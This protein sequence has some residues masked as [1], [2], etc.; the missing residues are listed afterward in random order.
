MKQCSTCKITKELNCFNYDK[1]R[2]SFKAKC[3]QCTAIVKK[4]WQQNNKQSMSKSFKKWSSKNKEHLQEYRIL[5]KECLIYRDKIRRR[6]SNYV[7]H[8]RLTDPL[9]LFKDKLRSL[10][11]KSLKNK[12][13]K[14]KSKTRDIVGLDFDKLKNYL[15]YTFFLNYGEE[16]KDQKIHIDHIV[17]L[18]SAK[19]EEEVIKLNHWTNLQY[20]TPEDNISKSNMI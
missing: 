9:Y 5:R 13:F 1:T 4:K 8:R 15:E 6:D 16:Y 12:N 10:I 11:K 3:K 18:A 7:K 19:T 14:K 2:N 17:P 20:L